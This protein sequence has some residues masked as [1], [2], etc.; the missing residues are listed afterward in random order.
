MEYNFKLCV[1]CTGDSGAAENLA[2]SLITRGGVRLVLRL[3][4]LWVSPRRMS[5]VEA[6]VL[7]SQ[8]KS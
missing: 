3:R 1:I 8:I 2:Y 7:C 4:R 5:A 6:F